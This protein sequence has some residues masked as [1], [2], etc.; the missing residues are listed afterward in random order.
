MK[1]YQIINQIY[2]STNSEVYRAIREAD[3][4]KIILK[5]IKQD[6]PTPQELIRY[7]QEYEIVRS[8]DS[9]RLIKAYSLEQVNPRLAIAL[10]D[11]GGRSLKSWINERNVSALP[12]EEFLKIA[13]AT[14]ESLENLHAANIIHKDINPANIVINPE[15]GELKLIDFGIST[16]LTRENPILK[17]PNVLEGTLAYISP[18]QTGRMNRY[19]DYRSDFYSLGI[20]FYELLTG[21]LPFESE[22]ALELVHCHIAQQP[23]S[24]QELNSEIP[25]TLSNIVMKLMAKTAEERYQTT[26]GIKA[27]LENCLEQYWAG[28]I[29]EFAIATQ[30]ISDKFQIP[31]KLY[32]RKAEIQTLLAAFARVSQGKTELMLVAGYSGI[33]KTSLVQEIYKPITEK[34]GY[35]ISGKF[36]QFQR[37]IPYSAVVVAFERLVKQLL[38]ETSQELN[39][40]REK[41]SNAVGVNGQVIIDTIPSVELII[42]KQPPV[43]EL[44]ATE[45][46]N[47]FNLVFQNFIRAFCAKEHPIVIFLDDIQWADSASLKLIELMMT[48]GDMKYLFLIGA[49]RD[50]EVSATHPLTMTVKALEQ[51]GTK[52]ERIT[53]TPLAGSDISQLIA[54]TLGRECLSVKQLAELAVNK[55][56][57]NP[58]FVNEFLKAL[59]QEN[60]IFFQRESLSWQWNLP[61]IASMESTNNVVELTISKL[62]KMPEVTQQLLSFAACIGAEFN[63]NILSI[64]CESSPGKVF[65]GLTLAIRSGLILAKAELDEELLIQDY[66]FMHD[67]F[68]Q[69]A[70]AIIDDKQKKAVHLRI[71]SLLLEKMSDAE[72]EEKIFDIVNHLNQGIELVSDRQ[73]K[74]KIAKLNLKVGS[75][76]R[77]ATAYESARQYLTQALNL[78]P[79]DAWENMYETTF[80]SY[81]EL[82]QCEYILGNPDEADKLFKIALENT[83]SKLDAAEIYDIKLQVYFTQAKFAKGIELGKEGLKMFGIVIPDAD[84]KLQLIEREKYRQVTSMLEE[85]SY[86]DI[87]NMPRMSDREKMACMKIIVFTWSHSILVGKTHLNNL[88]T[89]IG[90]EISLTSGNCD[91]SAY[92]YST[93]GMMLAASE[94]YTQGYEYGNLSLEL[95]QKFN[96]I[97]LRGKL[98]NHFCHFMNPYKRHIKTSI[99]LYRQSYYSCLECGDVVFG[100]WAAFFYIWHKFIKGDR[101]DEV[102]E[103][104]NN[105]YNF[106]RQ[107]NDINMFNILLLQR[108]VVLNLQGSTLD[109]NSLNAENFDE[110]SCLSTLKKNQFNFGMAW[111]ILFKIQILFVHGYEDSAFELWQQNQEVLTLFKNWI[112]ETEKIFYVS[113]ILVNFYTDAPTA[114]K[115]KL[116]ETIEL[117]LEKMKTWA[118]N[119]SENFRHKYLLVEAEIARVSGKDL[120]AMDFYDRAIESAHEHGFIQNEALSNELAAKFWLAKGKDKFARLYMTNASYYYQLWGATRKVEDLKEKYPQLLKSPSVATSSQKLSTTHTN[121]STSSSYGEG[122][123]LATVMKASQAI[124]GEIVL[125]KLLENL[126]KILMENAG[127]QVGYLL[128]YSQAD[129]CPEKDRFAIEVS[130]N[131]KLGNVT[132]LHS[133]SASEGIWAADDLNQVSGTIEDRLPM[134]IINYVARTSQR[135]VL[136]NAAVEGDFTNDRYI[137]QHQTESVLCAPLLDRGKLTGIV[138]LENNLTTGAFTQERWQMIK[139]LSGQAAIA[140]ANAK[141]YAEVRDRENQLTQFLD[142]MP[143]GVFVV[144]SQGK[145][146]YTNETGKQILGQG[147]VESTETEKLQA[148]YQVYL[149]DSDRLYPEERDPIVN[150]LQGKSVII[151]DME[152]RRP[153]KTIPIESAGSPIFDEK[154]N[155]AYA[156][157]AFSDISDRKQAEKL[158]A[159]YNRTLETQVKQRTSELS[160]ALEEL[161]TTQNEL[162]Q[163][164]KMAALGQLIAGVAHEINTPLGAITSSVRNISNFWSNNLPQLL[165]LWQQLSPQRQQDFLALIKKS[166]KQNTSLTTREQRQIKRALTQELESYNI[167]NVRTIAKY[168]IGIGVYENL[169]TFLALLQDTECEN[170]LKIA[171]QI[172][173]VITST[174]T[175]N[176][177]SERAGK[178]VFALKNYT[179]YDTTAELIEAQITE[180]LE[181]VLTLYY[182]QFKEGIEVIKNYP[183]DLPK[184]PCYPDELNQVWTN[185]IHNAIQAM[186]WKGTLTIDIQR[187]QE[188]ILVSIID[189]GKGIPPEILPKIF[190]PFFTTK[191]AGEGSGL[192]LDIVKKII[193]KHH[194]Q[195][196]VDSVP[197]KTTF[198]VCL[199]IDISC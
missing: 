153:D 94:D 68:Q 148:A 137:K 81:R 163:S 53:L 93:Y 197:G 173:N 156:I 60:L 54:D 185:L 84:E 195:I 165:S 48:D 190:Q 77:G 178:V 158:L 125:D 11:F 24:P 69:A 65:E 122:L 177:A 23:R 35:F 85:K 40:W 72:K 146:Y 74:N 41:I 39:R 134:S 110:E 167:K 142:A 145:P 91:V 108:G 155:V 124:S 164:E 37:N 130:G 132:V 169:E 58:F 101:L 198:T 25:T 176:T 22:D 104:I 193:D 70:Y 194:G 10:E 76:A 196:E 67:R 66:K 21:K 61:G 8:L 27:D 106:V 20:T 113:L 147:L 186:E 154:G 63:L 88:L 26:W 38:A 109:K 90:V 139:L 97:S 5:I 149:A 150:G 13:I 80:Q 36:D 46:Q 3:N 83:K 92:T 120:E 64:I 34:R 50:N 73:E 119:C 30:D 175:I 75:I 7:K 4:K 189:S 107:T 157:A 187:Q 182:N 9:D 43:A 16:K 143:V 32:G 168:L 184:I 49:Y 151:D 1:G 79:G 56:E 55:T 199:R 96:N 100:V 136:N 144:D 42:G 33:G 17:N 160:Q 152:I 161:Q 59:S 140:I 86:A 138:Y 179:H 166:N 12:L 95:N 105:Y 141:L 123:D 171:Y 126:M 174:F 111:Y 45:S 87:L 29:S 170:I 112:A 18:E 82:G 19:V 103:E 192:G 116:W 6:Y 62:K 121:V 183:E 14:V 117:Y 131:V 51:A 28:E 44:G 128:L 89:L 114:E 133:F 129:S 115:P 127:A 188:N 102:Y 180:G 52:I 71:G 47:R 159:D 181:T 57:G 135:V 2:S 98:L 31:Q 191:P 99:E 162:I 78:L 118:N 172:A 15:T